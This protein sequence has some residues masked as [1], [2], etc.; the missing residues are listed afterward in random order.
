MFI[1]KELARIAVGALAAGITLSFL[2]CS[3]GGHF[4]PTP[5]ALAPNTADGA[6]ANIVPAARDFG[7]NGEVLSASGVRVKIGRTQSVWNA[8]FSASGKA[9][10]P[11]AG[12][13]VAKGSWG[14]ELLHYH[15]RV[16]YF[17]EVFTIT[18]GAGRVDGIIYSRGNASARMSRRTFGPTKGGLAWK[19]ASGQGSVTT[20]R[21][22]SGFLV[23]RLY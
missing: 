6:I 19:G 3:G 22:R 13:F 14:V 7:L 18:S 1:P 23:E 11:Y 12:T 16:H 9:R 21:I 8:E 2:G 10:G 20:N 15:F 4:A 5:V 17:H